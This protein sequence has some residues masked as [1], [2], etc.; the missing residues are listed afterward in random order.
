MFL[1]GELHD[2]DK[3]F[4][5]SG[6]NDLFDRNMRASLQ[7]L[8][9]RASAEEWIP[10][11][12]DFLRSPEDFFLNHQDSLATSTSA[13]YIDELGK[14]RSMHWRDFYKLENRGDL[15]HLMVRTKELISYLL[16]GDDVYIPEICVFG[17]SDDPIPPAK[18]QQRWC[19]LGE[20]VVG[21]HRN[22][23]QIPPEL[24]F[25]LKGLFGFVDKEGQ[26]R[27]FDNTFSIQERLDG[28]CMGRPV[29]PTLQDFVSS[30][31][32][33]ADTDI[34]NWD[35]SISPH[36]FRSLFAQHLDLLGGWGIDP[37]RLTR[38]C[39]RIDHF[40]TKNGVT[41]D[42]AMARVTIIP[43]IVQPDGSRVPG[44]SPGPIYILPSGLQTTLYGNCL[45]HHAMLE[46]RVAASDF[47]VMGDDCLFRERA[48]DSVLEVYRN[49]RLKVKEKVRGDNTGVMF[50]SYL[51][52]KDG[53]ISLDRPKLTRR[54]LIRCSVDNT[55]LADPRYA[56]AMAVLYPEM[57]GGGAKERS[58]DRY[59]V[60]GLS[61]LD[62]E[63]VSALVEYLH[64]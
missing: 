46:T 14:K 43:P 29:L 8:L 40:W 48:L 17:K 35:G 19:L 42:A 26:F 4:G 12:G 36:C 49:A 60:D 15:F 7:T 62:A 55:C 61:G 44:K 25:V 20:E 11:I 57:G 34:S 32:E 23:F 52:D 47:M 56:P 10:S 38:V 41:S 50:C 22:I 28:H 1:G 16:G 31:D 27:V 37:S 6:D 58:G 39:C 45:V 59:R 13:S 18:Y 21:R 5:K 3:Q 64:D 2:Q 30:G 33:S 24:N 53:S 63:V 9:R 54:A 51:I